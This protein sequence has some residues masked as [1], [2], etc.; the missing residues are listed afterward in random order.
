MNPKILLYI[1]LL[2]L[3]FLQT[4]SKSYSKT[5][6]SSKVTKTT[7][8]TKTYTKK[9][10]SSHHDDDSDCGTPGEVVNLEVGEN[11]LTTVT[12]CGPEVQCQTVKI[13]RIGTRRVCKTVTVCRDETS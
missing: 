5:K 3:F 13:P 9:S 2:L 12:V 6:K 7:T 10:S 1:C 4:E 11:T 8:Y